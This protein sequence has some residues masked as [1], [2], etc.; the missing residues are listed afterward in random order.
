M[1][2]INFKLRFTQK[3]FQNPPLTYFQKALYILHQLE[4]NMKESFGNSS[5]NW[6]TDCAYIMKARRAIKPMRN[7]IS[8]H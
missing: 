2:R 5:Q 3:V 7:L 8:L 6:I 4:R 1:C